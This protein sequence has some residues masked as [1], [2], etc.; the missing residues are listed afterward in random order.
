MFSVE[1]P[2]YP[3]YPICSRGEYHCPPVAKKV[4]VTDP[5]PTGT[6]TAPTGNSGEA[7]EA[8]S[9][10]GIISLNTVELKTIEAINPL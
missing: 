8:S 4:K 1:A 10:T 2:Y 9:R 6:N 3:R 5:L 7:P